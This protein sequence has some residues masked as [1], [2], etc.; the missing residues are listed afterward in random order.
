MIAPQLDFLRRGDVMPSEIE[1]I[2]NKLR[3]MFTLQQRRNYMNALESFL[4][5]REGIKSIERRQSV[6]VQKIATNFEK[7]KHDYDTNEKFINEW[8]V[9]QFYKDYEH[10]IP[11]L[12]KKV[13][14]ARKLEL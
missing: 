1:V 11:E 9:L 8:N 14:G 2:S 13:K 12:R 3:A 7:K 5:D 4:P 6:I 10:D